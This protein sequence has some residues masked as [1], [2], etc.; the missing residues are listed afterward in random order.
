MPTPDEWFDLALKEYRAGTLPA[1]RILDLGRMPFYQIERWLARVP[2]LMTQ[3][4]LGKAEEKHL[5]DLDGFQGLPSRLQKPAAIF[6]SKDQ[7]GRFVIVTDLLAPDDNP[8]VVVV[9]PASN[10]D[11]GTHWAVA[12]VHARAAAQ[13]RRWEEQKLLR[14]VE[15]AKCRS[16]RK[17]IGQV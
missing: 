14:F 2:I 16:W 4:M 6:E 3:K 5:L 15:P 1:F 8:V 17:E 10:R 11:S 13:L 9:A 12:S 7:P